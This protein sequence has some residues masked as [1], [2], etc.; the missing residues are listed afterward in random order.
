MSDQM[1]IGRIEFGPCGCIGKQ[2]EDPHCPCEMRARG[3]E[4]TSFTQPLTPAEKTKL[5]EMFNREVR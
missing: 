4:R 3:L 1:T 2:G 5:S